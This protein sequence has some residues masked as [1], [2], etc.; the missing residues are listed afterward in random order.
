MDRCRYSRAI[1][2]DFQ[3]HAPFRN[4]PGAHLNRSTLAMLPHRLPRVAHQVHQHL[5]Q[6]PAVPLYERQHRIEIQL[7]VDFFGRQ[8][9]LLQFHGARDH[10]IQRNAAAL[11]TRLA[12]G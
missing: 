4:A 7:H 6:L 2:A 10:L 11:R 5:L 3:Q 1:I 12:R 8:A 9:E